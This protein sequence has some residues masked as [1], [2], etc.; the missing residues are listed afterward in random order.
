MADNAGWY[1]KKDEIVFG[2]FTREEILGIYHQGIIDEHA[3]TR[4][5]SLPWQPFGTYL[6]S[7]K[8][9]SRYLFGTEG[10]LQSLRD[11]GKRTTILFIVALVLLAFHLFT[12]TSGT[13]SRPAIPP[14]PPA[15]VAARPYAHPLQET[16]TPKKIL[17]YTNL[18]RSEHGLA[19]LRQNIFLDAIA[20]ERAKD[21][22][23]KGYFDHI[24]PTGEGASNIAQKAGYRYSRLGENIA[25]GWYLNDKE[26]VDGWM[27]SP[28]HRKNILSPD[29]AEIGVAVVKGTFEG[30]EA[31]IGVQVFGK[32]AEL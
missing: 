6:S 22:L 9:K 16:L 3:L 29:Y 18:A 30:S 10:I 21:M 8:N 32:Q 5:G 13:Q 14:V 19:E 11:P 17:Y 28:G 2:P 12:R 27:Q 23:E 7:H 31:M 25:R 26:I 15:P 1:Y 24:S 20:E 4:Y